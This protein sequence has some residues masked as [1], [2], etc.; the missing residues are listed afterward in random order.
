[1]PPGREE[2]VTAREVGLILMLRV[3]VADCGEG[4]LESV[5]LIVAAAVPTELS[6]GVP[7]IMPVVLLMVSPLGRLPALK[8]Y[9]V[10]P[11]DA[12]TALL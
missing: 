8:V 11:P 9:G 6:A 2:V 10:V 1:V 4:L 3:E 12:A 5:T 7:A